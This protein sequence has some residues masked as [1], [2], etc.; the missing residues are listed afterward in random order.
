MHAEHPA[1]SAP[2]S[3]QPRRTR[4]VLVWVVAALCILLA[5]LAAVAFTLLRTEWGAKTL[6][7]NA[8]RFI[9][10]EFTAEFQG[11][12][13]LDGLH[14][15]NVSYRDEKKQIGIDSVDAAWRFSWSPK[16]LH[17]RSLRIGTADVTLYPF[18]PEPATLPTQIRLPIHL[19]L[20][21]ASVQ[22]VLLHQEGK[23]S[24]YADIQLNASSDQVHHRLR[25][26]KAT[27][28][29]GDI[30]AALKLTGDRPFPIDGNASLATVY[31][32]QQVDADAKLS[33]SLQELGVKLA[34][35]G[36]GLDGNADI[37]ATPFA[38]V[39]L[40][41]AEV[42]VKGFDPRAINPDWPE[43]ELAINASLQPKGQGPIQNQTTPSGSAG[44]ALGLTV[45]GPVEIRN[46]KPGKIDEGRLPLDSAHAI[47][48]LDTQKQQLSALQVKLPGNATLEGGG[49][50]KTSGNGEFSFRASKLDLRA[51]HGALVTT[52]LAG[53]L[54][55]KLDNGNQKIQ[56]DLTGP[57]LSARVDAH[58]TPAAIT[59]H[60]AQLVSG[61]AKL[62]LTGNLDRAEPSAFSFNGS[63]SNFDPAVVL[64]NV[65]P[66]QL[67]KKTRGRLSEIDANINMTFEA[68]GKLKP[69]P[70][71]KIRFTVGESRYAGLPLTGGG[72]V[73]F[74]GKRV[75]PS[76]A[77]ISVAGNEINL[78]GSFGQPSDRLTFHADAPFL[79]RLGYGL[80]GML[81]ADGEIS[82]TT[83]SPRVDTQYRA[84]HLAF[85]EHR[86]A[87]LSGSAR[88]NGLPGTAPDAG[89][90]LDLTARDLRSGDIRLGKVDVAINGS[91]A[92]HTVRLG[93][94]GRLRGARLDLTLAAQGALRQQKQGF[95]WDGVV[96]NL[97]NKGLPEFS[98]AAP[99]KLD[100]APG[101]LVLG[102]ARLSFADAHIDVQGI[103]YSDGR[104][105]SEG[106]FSALDI[107]RVL[108]LQEQI[109]GT[110]P[111]LDTN[112]VLDGSWNVTLADRA[113][114][115]VLV[116]RR[117]GDIRLPGPV[118]NNA[119]GLNALSLRA[120]LQGQ[121]V[122][123]NARA[124]TQQIGSLEGQGK[125][126]LQQRDGSWTVSPD[127][128]VNGRV[129]A[130]IPRLSNLAALAGPRIALNGQVALDV[131]VNGSLSDPRLSGYING[132]R[133]ALTLYEQGV[134]LNDG[135]ARIVLDNN[136][137]DL[138]Q[139]MFRGGDGT[140]TIA[141]RIP[142]TNEA[143]DLQATI[144]ADKLQLLASPAGQ[145]TVSGQAIAARVNEQLQVTGKFDVD[146]ALFSLPEKSAPKLDDDVVIIRGDQPPQKN[147]A[148]DKA[149]KSSPYSPRI[150][151]T[152]GLGR[153]FRFEGA[154]ADL[155]LA[156]SV[157]IIGEPAETPQA[158]G[159]VRIA[160]G[161]YEAF[162]TKL[163]V[164]RG[165]INFDGPLTNPNLNILAMRRN[166]DV[167]AGVQVTG[168]VSQ[169]RVQLVSEPN[170]AEEE[171][172]SWLI[173]GRS[174]GSAAQGQAQSAAKGAALGLLNKFGG[175]RIAKGF[176]LDEFSIGASEFG[177]GGG[178]VVN[179]GKELTD[180]LFIG[181]EQ[182]LAGAES[183]LK[184]T[185][186]L[187]R[188]WTV[189]VRGG[190]VAGLDLFYS[191]RFDKFGERVGQRSGS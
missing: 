158:F 86:L 187:T 150:D 166:Q 13:L 84:E 160:E 137:V 72:L 147:A 174:G 109:T 128:P 145:L 24:R 77:R 157:R 25:L 149:P 119:L 117:R 186:E 37:E 105:R 28:P 47:V 17:I 1:T 58:L 164:E 127:A 66:A 14:L 171:K 120:D 180:R 159:T 69:E 168:T 100:V 173:F 43:A 42:R 99:V 132:D 134:R 102:T 36:K 155:R 118:A 135:T 110:K 96:Q 139:V 5:L 176:G 95:Q 103:D 6:L 153:N 11:G 71:A 32:D 16:T 26:E 142:L 183:V 133:L 55:I 56:L 111:P 52:D 121:E 141:G 49:E 98:L 126:S 151:V 74:A 51:L 156:G 2:S 97:Q 18:P 39:P 61:P 67:D 12:T 3:R 87:L 70:A 93:T 34:I 185:Y 63:L 68:D 22:Q 165:V 45:T 29:F 59:L 50:L 104:L 130:S 33:G 152:V 161:S 76:D 123:L 144:T 189:V 181:Y 53:P 20:D 27:T 73:Q 182:S 125:I 146:R 116:E 108:A 178:Q 79:G 113:D 78:K 107:G 89:L 65:Q 175:S 112:L 48:T 35:I 129:T 23:D 163:A 92:Q 21:N 114:G 154:G 188:Y 62:A 167:A 81:Q 15:R 60:A 41:R 83:D 91:Y 80:S 124:G 9:P 4:H 75:L 90:V 136:I 190:T 177:L 7:Q 44:S 106:A 30:K 82:G 179:L 94:D 57:R 54:D 101:H 143:R 8:G 46:G 169:P 170:V 140:L 191:K 184:L 138:R 162:G 172:L 88:M 122:V 19:K 131:S 40:R 148:K 38:D 10:G 64:A 85:G 115:F 31:R